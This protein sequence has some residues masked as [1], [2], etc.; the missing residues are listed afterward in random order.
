MSVGWGTSETK[1]L[2][3][4]SAFGAVARLK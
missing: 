2:V 1:S 4:K 3:D